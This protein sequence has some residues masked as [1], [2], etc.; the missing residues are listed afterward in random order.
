MIKQLGCV[1][2]ESVV[3]AMSLDVEPEAPWPPRLHESVALDTAEGRSLLKKSIG[4][5]G[6]GGQR[7]RSDDGRQGGPMR[8]IASI[9]ANGDLESGKTGDLTSGQLA[10]LRKITWLLIILVVGVLGMASLSIASIVIVSNKATAALTTA[11]A[12]LSPET[13]DAVIHNG[14]DSINQVHAATVSGAAAAS[15]IEAATETVVSA[16]NTTAALLSDVCIH[17]HT[18]IQI[19]NPSCLRPD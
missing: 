12:H 3:A 11:M 17:T 9:G 2:M 8:V 10:V 5:G 6:G 14:V 18:H 19:S 13:I 15:Q 4:G 1:V 7:S 16:V